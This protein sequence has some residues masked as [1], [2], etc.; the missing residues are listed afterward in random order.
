MSAEALLQRLEKVKKTGRDKWLASCPAHDDKGPSLAIRETDTGIVLLH[1]FAGCSPLEVLEAIGLDFTSL[2][3]SNVTDHSTKP[4]RKPWN[5]SDALTG[6]AFES[7]VL[8]QYA[9][10]MAT[11]T[12]LTDADHERLRLSAT[13]IQ[14]ARETT[15]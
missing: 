14:R 6:L 5:A 1:C 10:L 2:Y 4:V 15:Q 8:L 11:G 12:T 13:R 9:Q 3:P 7:L